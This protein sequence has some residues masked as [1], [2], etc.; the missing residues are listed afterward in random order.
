MMTGRESS[1]GERI[2]PY[3]G[4]QF[5]PEKV[6]VRGRTLYYATS[7]CVCVRRVG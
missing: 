4:S 7:Y 5:F 6:G 1:Q 3:L 2:I